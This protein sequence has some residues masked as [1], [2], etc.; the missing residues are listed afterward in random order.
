MN[1]ISSIAASGLKVESQ[2]LAVSANNVANVQSNGFVPREVA[3]QEQQGGGVQGQVTPPRDTQADARVDGVIVASKTDLVNETVTQSMA[4]AA[5][6][7][8]LAVLKT[9]QENMEAVISIK[10]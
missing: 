1:P 3:S 4:S 10:R 8:N 5:F 2:R 6:K 7:A 9:D